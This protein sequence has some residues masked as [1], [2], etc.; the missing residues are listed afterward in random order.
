[1]STTTT[2]DGHK[3]VSCD[4]EKEREDLPQETLTTNKGSLDP[5]EGSE[6]F[7]GDMDACFRA[8]DKDGDSS[9]NLAE[10]WA[11]CR[12]L[13][14]D[15]RGRPYPLES[16]LVERLFGI[17]DVNKDKVIDKDEFRFCWQRWIK[18]IVRPIVALIVVD[19]QND[20][21]TGSL[22][23]SNCP[24]G[25]NGEEVIPIINR[26]EEEVP[27]HVIV[28]SLDWHPADHVSFIDNV[29]M[30]PMHKTSKSEEAQVYDTV[31]FDVKRD[32]T[33]TT[34][35]LWPRH[36]VQ[37]S[38]GAELHKELK[39]APEGILVYKGT[40]P[41]LDSYSAFWDNNK[42]SHTILNEE[43]QKKNVTDVIICGIAYDICVAATA[44]HA[45]EEGYRTIVVDDACRGVSEEE[46][47]SA[48]G[49]LTTNHCLVIPS[50]QVKNLASGRDRPPVLGLK[51]AL[52]LG[53]KLKAGKIRVK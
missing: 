1:M 16:D 39:V 22:A 18:K 21:I 14:R 8:F 47:E 29:R 50:S 9:L 11:L 4:L 31:V 24:A 10:F 51:L 13:F 34:Q 32:G 49:R 19:V 37:K 35:M 38:W 41:D 43:L 7:L 53:K 27:F 5:A 30:R 26:L 36:C 46:I 12:A 48:K 28:Y 45:N 3:V 23:I 15:E 2:P 6:V 20:F 52:E 33:P 25:H 42:Q 40:D 44:S 17:F